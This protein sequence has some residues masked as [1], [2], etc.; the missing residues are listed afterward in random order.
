MIIETSEN[1]E[2]YKENLENALFQEL[3][4]LILKYQHHYKVSPV[5]DLTINTVTFKEDFQIEFEKQMPSWEYAKQIFLKRLIKDAE[6]LR[7]Q[8][9]QEIQKTKN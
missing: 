4:D 5:Q 9:D 1:A 8:K 6:M 3:Q 2:I 7:I